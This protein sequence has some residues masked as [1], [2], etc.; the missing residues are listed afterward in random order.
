VSE[1]PGAARSLLSALEREHIPALARLTQS[2]REFLAP[3]SPLR[4]EEYFTEEGQERAALESLQSAKNGTAL[5]MVIVDAAG[6]LVG[7]LNFNSIIRGAFQSASIAYWVSQDRN[8][9]GLAS[10]AVAAAK[11]IASDQLGLHRLQ[12][13]TLVDNEASER[14]LIKNGFIQYGQAP[15]YLKIAGRW[16]EHR[17]FQVTFPAS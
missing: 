9:E 6:N 16:Q 14:V 13:E 11:Q 7:T 17:L 4:P 1:A 10:A 2:N 15:E 3:T 12:A 8:G 5:P